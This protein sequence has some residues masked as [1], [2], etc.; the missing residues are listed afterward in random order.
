[1]RSTTRA[2]AASMRS[3]PSPAELHT[4]RLLLRRWRREDREP[5]AELNADLAVMEHFPAPLERAASDALADRL[6]AHVEREGWGLWAV[7]VIDSGDFVGFTGL[8]VPGFE[9]H[10]TPAVEIGWRLAT[11]AWGSG[12]AT[13]AARA[14]LSFGFGSLGLAEIVSFAARSNVRSHAVMRRIGM[15]Y[16]P[17]DDFP[18]PSLAPDSPIRQHVLYRATPGA[19]ARS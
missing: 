9:A 1:M 4:E 8:S 3:M 6:D 7:E 15:S 16:D 18:H 5:F 11:R 2:R 12:Y 10:F 17:A 14:A 19:Y 13:E